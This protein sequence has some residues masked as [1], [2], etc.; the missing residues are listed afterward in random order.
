MTKV[1]HIVGNGDSYRFYKPAPGIKMTCNVPPTDIKDVY[2]TAIVD[3]KMCKAIHEGSIDLRAY[4]WVMGARPK[5]YMEMQ[6]S[7]YMQYSK[8]I[9]EF[10]TVLPRYAKNYT[11][12]NCGPVS[13]THLTLPTKRIV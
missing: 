5:K 8:N 10:Y 7:F 12:F 11:D 13:Y 3:F 2:A 6:P 4:D 1:A 9:K